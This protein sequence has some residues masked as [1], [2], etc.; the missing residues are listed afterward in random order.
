MGGMNL[1]PEKKPSKLKWLFIAVS[2]FLILCAALLVASI[3]LSMNYKTRIYPGIMVGDLSVGGLT[4]T[5]AAEIIKGDFKQIY[6][7]G[8]NFQLDNETKTVSNEG[9]ILKLNLDSL[10]DKAFALGHFG[11]WWDRSWPTIVYPV[12]K[13]TL[14]LDYRFDKD[15]LKTSLQDAFQAVETPARNSEVAVKIVDLKTRQ[16]E[17]EFSDSSIGQTFNYSQAIE[18]LDKALKRFQNPTLSLAK[19]NDFPKIT[20]DM[21]VAQKDKIDQLLR[22]QQIDLSFQNKTWTIAWP[23][24]ARSIKVALDDQEKPAVTLDRDMIKSQLIAIA[25]QVNRPA[26]DAKI[27][28]QN[29]RATEF[30]SSQTGQELDVEKNYAKI[31]ENVLSG[32]N[33]IELIVDITEPKTKIDSINELGIKEKISVGVSDFSGSPANR[34][35]NI[36]IGA[37]ALNGLIIKQGEEFSLVAALGDIDAES[38]Y[39]PELVIKQNKT[40]PEF[41][42]GLCQ[43]GTTLFRVALA[44]GVPVTARQNHTYRVVYYEPAGTDATIYVPRPDVKFIN[45]TPSNILIQTKQQGNILTFEFWG[46]R[47]S[48]AVSFEGLNKTDDLQKLKP[49]IFNITNPGP[50]KEI[51]TTELAPGVKKRIDT[52]HNGADTI[53]Y[54][55]ITKADGTNSKETWKSHYVPWQAVFLIGVDPL[56]VVPPTTTPIDPENIIPPTV[57]P[58]NSTSANKL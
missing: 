18:T 23:D 57:A 17:L 1:I 54:R 38:G 42:G 49:E 52:A 58:G 40:T 15:A 48:R 37:A 43:I 56:K 3:A 41:G 27:R 19:Q 21:A 53:F 44:A 4:K 10:V 9:E 33:K 16:Y 5:Q 45:D 51:E 13:K 31:V 20:R 28:V 39:L 50:P 2:A 47:D 35:H 12:F 14:P 55:Y 7:R 29:N 26:V 11:N 32:N 24:F 25:Q 34:I 6:G 30:Q 36:G 8:F 22:I 46:T